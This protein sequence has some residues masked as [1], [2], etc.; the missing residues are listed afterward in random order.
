MHGTFANLYR[1]K[2]ISKNISKQLTVPITHTSQS[3]WN[4][5]AMIK[6]AQEHE[7]KNFVNI[8]EQAWNT[9]THSSVSTGRVKNKKM[10][11]GRRCNFRSL[12]CYCN[13]FNS[14][15]YK[16][17]LDGKCPETGRDRPSARSYSRSQPDEAYAMWRRQVYKTLCTCRKVVHIAWTYQSG[18]KWRERQSKQTNKHAKWWKK[19]RKNEK[20][21]WYEHL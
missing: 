20:C 7:D 6:R 14:N 12:A 16:S 19:M 9:K 18:R 2:G 5:G 1:N 17:L 11:T 10:M 15:V 4:P 8:K 3:T 13:N 21:M